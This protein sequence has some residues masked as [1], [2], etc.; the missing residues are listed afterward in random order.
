ML[1]ILLATVL[2][3]SPMLAHAA[4]KFI[5]SSPDIKAGAIM[6]G[7]YVYKGYGCSGGNLSPALSWQNAPAGTKSFALT[8]Y[9][10]DAKTGSG[11][12][13]WVVFN[14][15]A[16]TRSFAEGSVPTGAEQSRTDFGTPGYG[17]PCPP[18]G[19]RPHHYI[20]T[21]YALKTGKLDLATDAPAAMVGYMINGNK[22][23]QASFTALY[24]R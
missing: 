21:I 3:L 1:R 20:F 4:G 18:A 16:D 10:P 17:G 22:I 2:S 5:L 23:G 11:W 8:V 6:A 9:D 13:H 14:I 24:G 12:W 19:D 7:K 15:P